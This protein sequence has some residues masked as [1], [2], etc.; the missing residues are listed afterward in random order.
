MSMDIDG[1]SPRKGKHDS[2]ADHLKASDFFPPGVGWNKAAEQDPGQQRQD[3][4]PTPRS[5]IEPA[6]H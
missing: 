5:P 2:L 4:R 6:Q 1:Q 3:V